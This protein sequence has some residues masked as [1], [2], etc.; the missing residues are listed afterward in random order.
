MEFKS[1]KAQGG[2]TWD[3][4]ALLPSA[5]LSL[6]WCHTTCYLPESGTPTASVNNHLLMVLKESL[7]SAQLLVKPIFFLFFFKPQRWCH[8]CV[9]FIVR[10]DLPGMTMVWDRFH[11][12]H[13]IFLEDNSGSE[14]WALTGGTQ[15]TVSEVTCLSYAPVI[16]YLSPSLLLSVPLPLCLSLRQ[17]GGTNNRYSSADPGSSRWGPGLVAA[18]Q[19]RQNSGTLR[20]RTP[21][22][23]VESTWWL[24]SV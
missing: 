21:H 23:P 20:M 10:L 17:P 15:V 1:T 4:S 6:Q 16:Y 13:L 18:I 3:L 2:N 5:S 12:R 9:S 8:L 22:P 24:H 19:R 11:T 14:V 7:W